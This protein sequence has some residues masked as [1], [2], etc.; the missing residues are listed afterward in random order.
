VPNDAKLGMVAGVALV[1][2]VA[3]VFFRRDAAAGSPNGPK[4]VTPAPRTPGGRAPVQAPA[5][6]APEKARRA[7]LS[8]LPPCTSTSLPST[9]AASFA[10]GN[11]TG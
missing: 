2:V 7:G 11:W 9:S 8:S 4:A 1:I 3:I 5:R 10:P 6:P